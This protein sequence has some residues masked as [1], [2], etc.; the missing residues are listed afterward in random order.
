MNFNKAVF[1]HVK[2]REESEKMGSKKLGR[3]QMR[4]KLKNW[5][6]MN[7]FSSPLPIGKRQPASQPDRLT[8]R[9][10]QMDRV[11]DRRTDRQTGRQFVVAFAVSRKTAS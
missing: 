5:P 3:P 4:E 9:Q 1:I 8:D 2:I 6:Q 10:R 11:K 7:D